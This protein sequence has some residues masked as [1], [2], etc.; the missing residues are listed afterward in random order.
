MSKIGK[1]AGTCS[2]CSALRCHHPLQGP[3]VLGLDHHPV[4]QKCHPHQQ[5]QEVHSHFC[6]LHSH[7]ALATPSLPISD[8]SGHHCEVSH[9]AEA[10]ATTSD[11]LLPTGPFPVPTALHV[12]AALDI[13]HRHVYDRHKSMYSSSYSAEACAAPCGASH[14]PNPAPVLDGVRA[15]D[16]VVVVKL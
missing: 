12:R 16:T 14:S 4:A 13:R 1:S 6:T 7:A 5:P 11:H 8:P 2:I 10:C 15:Q 3:W 9:H